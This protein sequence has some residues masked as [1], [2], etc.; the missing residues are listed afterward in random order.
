MHYNR[1]KMYN[2]FF[3]SK[4]RIIFHSCCHQMILPGKATRHH[5]TKYRLISQWQIKLTSMYFSMCMLFYLTLCCGWMLQCIV[6]I[7]DQVEREMDFERREWR[8]DCLLCVSH[9]NLLNHGLKLRDLWICGNCKS[10][11]LLYRST[12]FTPTII[13]LLFVYLYRLYPV[14]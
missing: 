9:A 8:W 12:W 13:D 14:L 5:S 2:Y 3:F 4:D 7:S 6:I 11:V 10:S 1:N